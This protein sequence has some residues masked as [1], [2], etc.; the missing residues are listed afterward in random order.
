LAKGTAF[1]GGY[2]TGKNLIEGKYEQAVVD[3]TGTAVLTYFGSRRPCKNGPIEIL[4]PAEASPRTIQINPNSYNIR[5]IH[6]VGHTPQSIAR[7]QNTVPFNQALSNANQ[8]IQ[9]I[10]YNGNYYVVSGHHRIY[11]IRN[12]HTPP[13]APPSSVEAQVFTPQE[14]AQYPGADPVF[15]NNP[16]NLMNVINNSESAG[17]RFPSKP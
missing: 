4:N 17:A 5:P 2:S 9:L 3:A 15:R 13:N 12:L 1:V 6:E 7:A 14:Y 16:Q 8:P 10:E 11:G